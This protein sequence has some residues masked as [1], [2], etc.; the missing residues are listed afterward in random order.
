MICGG[1]PE[2]ERSAPC[3]GFRW[4]PMKNSEMVGRD[5]GSLGGRKAC[6]GLSRASLPMALALHPSYSVR[7]ERSARYVPSQLPRG[8]PRQKE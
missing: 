4:A 5:F 7:S 8:Q 1:E 2:R 6:T 3:R